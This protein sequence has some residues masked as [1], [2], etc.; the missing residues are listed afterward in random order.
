MNALALATEGSGPSF[1]VIFII[2][3][4]LGV[5]IFWYFKMQKESKAQKRSQDMRDL[6]TEVFVETQKPRKSA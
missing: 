1:G 6:Y 4:L 2:C 3:A 5:A